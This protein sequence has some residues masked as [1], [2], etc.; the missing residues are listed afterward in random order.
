[1]TE[2]EAII[3]N[4]REGLS[5][6]VEHLRA[7]GQ[8]QDVAA[9]LE[10][11]LGIE[12]E[13]HLHLLRQHEQLVM[14]LLAYRIHTI[15]SLL[16]EVCPVC[17]LGERQHTERCRIGLALTLLPEGMPPIEESAV[18]RLAVMEDAMELWITRLQAGEVE[19][20][21]VDMQTS[22]K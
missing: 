8:P 3:E 20:V 5:A 9:N 7:G 16:P 18:R 19:R 12:G 15:E 6:S 17:H 11:L 10:L 13:E 4:L 1:V 2:Q 14:A 22:L 21:L